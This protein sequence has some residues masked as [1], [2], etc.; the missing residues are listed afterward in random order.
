MVHMPRTKVQDTINDIHSQ[1][2]NS[3]ISTPRALLQPISVDGH[4]YRISLNIIGLLPTTSSGKRFILVISDYFTKWCK[5]PDSWDKH[6]SKCQLAYR[7][8]VHDL[9]GFSPVLPQHNHELRIPADI[10]PLLIPV[11]EIHMEAYNRAIKER[12]VLTDFLPITLKRHKKTHQRCYEEHAAET[13]Y[14]AGDSVLLFRARPPIGAATKVR[15]PWL[16][17]YTFVY[18]PFANTFVLRDPPTDD[19]FI[20]HYNQ[21]KPASCRALTTCPSLSLVPPL[22][23]SPWHRRNTRKSPTSKK[24]RKCDEVGSKKLPSKCVIAREAGDNCLESSLTCGVLLENH[25]EDNIGGLDRRLHVEVHLEAGDLERVAF[26]VRELLY[27][28]D[29]E[30]RGRI[31]AQ[32]QV[33][34]TRWRASRKFQKISHRVTP[35]R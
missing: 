33:P 17:P 14:R 10:P 30:G 15:C 3:P 11:E 29:E 20:V 8:T 25:A 24:Y 23:P 13:E 21:I 27:E 16:T 26:E 6:M 35:L 18:Q 12:L 19:V 34:P 32:P 28:S 31:P 9:T 5:S 22:I 1:F 4:N 7:T 2:W